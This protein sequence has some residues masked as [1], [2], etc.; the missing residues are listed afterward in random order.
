MDYSDKE[1]ESIISCFRRILR[2]RA[3]LFHKETKDIIEALNGLKL[4]YPIE[5]YQFTFNI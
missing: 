5:D 4:D 2:I 3:N 1:S